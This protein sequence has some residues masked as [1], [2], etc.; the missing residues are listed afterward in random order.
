VGEEPEYG[1]A[2]RESECYDV[3]DERIGE[4]F[5]D[6]FGDVEGGYVEDCIGI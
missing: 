6:S 1:A 2:R 4:V 3:Q 5:G